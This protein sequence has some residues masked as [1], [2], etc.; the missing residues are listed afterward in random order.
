MK[1]LTS[2][3]LLTTCFLLA[4]TFSAQAADE[5][6]ADPTGTWTWS[7]PGRN[8]GEPRENTLTIK[9]EGDKLVGTLAGGRGGETKI[10]N[11]KMT[12]EELS[13]DVTREVQGNSFTSK[14]KGKVAGDT[15]T[16]KIARERDGETRETDWTAK[17]KKDEKKEAA[18]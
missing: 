16:G 11:A 15:I 3:S 4:A 5:K 6:K 14:Y 12:G 17:R 9:K 8:G 1:R 13:F 10:Q 18:K 7:Q 2:W